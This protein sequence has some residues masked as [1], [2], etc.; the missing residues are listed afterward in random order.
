[1]VS[2]FRVRHEYYKTLDA[3]NSFP[4]P[5][6]LLDIDF[7]FFAFLDWFGSKSIRTATVAPSFITHRHVPPPFVV[8]LFRLLQE[9][10][11]VVS[12]TAAGRS[13]ASQPVNTARPD[14]NI[15]LLSK[16]FRDRGNN[17]GADEFE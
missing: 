6:D 17:T 9:K 15:N 14:D 10:A 8:I 3:S 4:A 2:G 12:E 7:V 1:M 13:P 11:A 16:V 5:T